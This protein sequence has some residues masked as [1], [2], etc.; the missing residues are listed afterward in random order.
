MERR[1]SGR[2][3]VDA[4]VEVSVG[5]VT[6]KTH[7]CN[8]SEEGALLRIEKEDADSLS[9]DDLAEIVRFVY[10]GF[11][12]PEDSYSGEVARF[13]RSGDDRYLAVR[14]FKRDG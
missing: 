4:P 1:N 13:F 10:S 12:S 11:T 9:N 8:I 3:E 7:M 2:V 5:D 14:F 6:I